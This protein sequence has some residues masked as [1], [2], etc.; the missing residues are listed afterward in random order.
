MITF[1]SSDDDLTNPQFYDPG[2]H[3]K[4]VPKV[5]GGLGGLNLYSTHRGFLHPGER[6]LMDTRLKLEV[7]P[8]MQTRGYFPMIFGHD[9]LA[10]QGIFVHVGGCVQLYSFLC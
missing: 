1:T 3:H 9:G 2:G 5:Y 7:N 6:V 8:E 4:F 10:K